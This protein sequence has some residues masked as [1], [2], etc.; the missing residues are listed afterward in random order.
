MKMNQ[1]GR[2]N[3][4]FCTPD[5][6]FWQLNS[7]FKFELDAAANGDNHLCYCYFTK[8]QNGLNQ[9]WGG[10]QLRLLIHHIVKFL[11]GLRNVIM[12]V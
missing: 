6:I 9:W 7:I 5:Y 4:E 8:E 1:K 12:K 11:H 2:G 10:V 3:D